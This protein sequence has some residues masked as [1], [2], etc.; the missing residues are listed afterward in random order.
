MAERRILG[1]QNLKHHH[2]SPEQKFLSPQFSYW[3]AMEQHKAR[4]YLHVRGLLSCRIVS[5]ST[6][7]DLPQPPR[8]KAKAGSNFLYSALLKKSREETVKPPFQKLALFPWQETKD[9]SLQLHVRP[10]PSFK[11]SPESF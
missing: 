8:H 11:Q 7:R 4:A 9:L 6:L 5:I 3:P 1:T 2:M 10:Y